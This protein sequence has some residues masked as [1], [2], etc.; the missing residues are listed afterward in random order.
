MA[1]RFRQDYAATGRIEAGHGYA[2]SPLA[3]MTRW[4]SPVRGIRAGTP[5]LGRGTCW[6]CGRN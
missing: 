6:R 3:F 1:A 2:D 4:I 5:L